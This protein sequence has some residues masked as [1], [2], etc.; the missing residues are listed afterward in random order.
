MEVEGGLEVPAD[1]DALVVCDDLVANGLDSLG[2]RL[3]P[4]N[5]TEYKIMSHGSSDD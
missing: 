2:V 5:L 4:A 1:G 3:H